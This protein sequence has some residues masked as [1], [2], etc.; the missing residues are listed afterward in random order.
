[1]RHDYHNMHTWHTHVS[2][3]PSSELR[4]MQKYINEMR[5]AVGELVDQ[6]VW[7][8]MDTRRRNRTW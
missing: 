6:A 3:Y 4:E 7:F 5:A 2:M 1:M 8:G